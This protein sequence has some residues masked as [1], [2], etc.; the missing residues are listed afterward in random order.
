MAKMKINTNSFKNKIMNSNFSATKN[1][2]YLLIAPALILLVG[3]ILLCTIG[4]NLGTDFTGASTFKVYVNNENTFGE[5]LVSYNLDNTSDYN[6]IYNKIKIVL[7]ENGLTIREYKTTTINITNYHIYSGQAIEVLYQNTV[8]DENLI[9]DQNNDIRNS[10]ISAF[11]YNNFDDAVS[12]VDFIPASSSF[13]WIIGIIA[14]IIF[15]YIIIAGYM[16]F[17][18]NPSIFIVG[19]L[20][21]A[22]D[23]FLVIALTLICRLMINL[24]FGVV[25]FAT[26]ILTIFNLFYYYLKIKDN[27]KSGKFIN[28]KNSVIADTTNKEITL[29]RV[30]IYIILL[31]FSLIF[32]LL[33]VEGVREVALGILLSVIATFYTSQFITPTLWA[34]CNK[35]KKTAPKNKNPK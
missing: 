33:A 27:V 14:G 34:T 29:N 26:L 30:V 13:G 24:S 35:T 1:F 18:Y 11:G 15:S 4:F 3:I 16:A 31:I 10:I 20:Q 28:I 25:L 2:L 7:E 8:S 32:S 22:L 17:R 6:E 5:D 21:I 19:L 9:E 23:I 12:S